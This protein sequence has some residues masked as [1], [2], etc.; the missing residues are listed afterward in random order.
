MP[1]ALS[2]PGLIAHRHDRRRTWRHRRTNRRPVGPPLAIKAREVDHA[3]AGSHGY[4][5][6]LA[7][8]VPHAGLGL[9]FELTIAYFTGLSNERDA[10]PFPRT[11]GNVR[12]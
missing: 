4:S 7:T 3:V 5:C 9:G 11:P 1:A 6:G 10:I 2:D 12:Y 8:M